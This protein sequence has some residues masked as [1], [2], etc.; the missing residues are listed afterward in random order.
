MSQSGFIVL[1]AQFVPAV[2]RI[3][4]GT[5]LALSLGMLGALALLFWGLVSGLGWLWGQTQPLTDAAP[6]AAR[7]VIAQ[8]ENTI[9]GARDKLA[10]IMPALKPEPAPRDVSGTDIGPVARYP[11]LTRSHWHREGREITV[12]Y[13][14]PADYARVLDHYVRGFAAQGYAQGVLSASP[15]LEKHEYLK[16]SD[17]VA[18][19]LTQLPKDKVKVSLVAV[20]PAPTSA[21]TQP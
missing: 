16:G 21:K 10:E 20:L 17:R 2:F 13:E 6:E 19:T 5:W 15:G 14:G 1:A 4:S 11:G 18:F 3:R 8:V 9:P 7:S 12:R